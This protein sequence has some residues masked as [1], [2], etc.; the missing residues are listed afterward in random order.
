M[1]TEPGAGQIVRRSA[2]N[3]RRFGCSKEDKYR[4][5]SLN[6]MRLSYHKPQCRP[7]GAMTIP[8]HVLPRSSLA[9]AAVVPLLT[10]ALVA[11]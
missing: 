2:S 1:S 5:T 7:S 10:E 6:D 11:R 4:S 8:G 3:V 9:V